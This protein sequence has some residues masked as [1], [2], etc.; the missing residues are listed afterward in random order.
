MNEAMWYLARAGGLTAYLLVT[1]SVALGLVTSLRVAT[2]AWPRSVITEIHRYITL[3]G[4]VFC[5]I[6]VGAILLDRQ[7][8]VGPVAALVPFASDREPLGMALGV[9]GLELMAA[10]ALSIRIRDRIGYRAWRRLHYGAF[11]VFAMSLV[12]GVMTGTDG[13]SAI[14]ALLYVLSVALILGLVVA[15]VMESRA[16]SP[17]RGARRVVRVARPVD[18]GGAPGPVVLPRSAATELP[19]LHRRVPPSPDGLPP[20]RSSP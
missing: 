6:H 2:P 18:A 19:E 11:G 17:R 8:G 12:H 1:A 13:G 15:R 4:M 7:A 14:V 16:P 20:L 3:V 9:V 5:G 10:I